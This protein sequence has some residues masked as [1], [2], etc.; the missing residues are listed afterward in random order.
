MIKVKFESS[1]K[2][3]VSGIASTVIT[4]SLD[5]HRRYHVKTRI[6]DQPNPKMR[7]GG[8]EGTQAVITPLFLDAGPPRPLFVWVFVVPPLHTDECWR[9]TRRARWLVVNLR[10]NLAHSKANS[11]QF[12]VDG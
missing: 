9:D 11:G 4:W 6:L 8:Y 3:D 2:F 5:A 12:E 10:P 7:P 1:I